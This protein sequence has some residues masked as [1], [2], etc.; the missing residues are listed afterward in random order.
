MG[1]FAAQDD[2]KRE[3]LCAKERLLEEASGLCV[4][5]EP[6]TLHRSVEE[7]ARET[8]KRAQKGDLGPRE[9][10]GGRA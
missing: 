4:G 7:S 9:C 3:A 8:R 10:Q 6:G 5:V 1:A 2:V